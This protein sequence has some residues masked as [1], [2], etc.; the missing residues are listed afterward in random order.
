[1]IPTI[2]ADAVQFEQ[3]NAFTEGKGVYLKWSM[4]SETGNVGFNI[5]RSTFRRSE[6]VT[7]TI[8]PGGSARSSAPTVKGEMY[9]YFD[10]S[11]TL[12]ATYTIKSITFAGERIVSSPVTSRFSAD[13]EKDTGRSLKEL[14]NVEKTRNPSIAGRSLSLTPELQAI[15]RTSQQQADLATHRWVVSQP[16]AK[17][18]VKK[19]GLYR[20]SRSDLQNA[21]FNVSSTSANWRLFMEG[22]EQ[23]I[24]VGPS[25]DYIEFYGKGIDTI[26]S[27]TR[28]YYLLAD[29]VAGKRMTTKILSTLG[30]NAV[31]PNYRVVSEKKEKINYLNSIQNGDAENY[32]GR[33][34]TSSPTTV[35][36]TLTG[37]DTSVAT[38]SITVKMQGFS[39]SVHENNVILNGHNLGTFTGNQRDAYALQDFVIPTSFLVEGTNSL[40]L[41]T[42]VSSD[43]SLFDSVS[44]SFGRK[45]QADQNKVIFYTPGYRRI[46]ASGF[47]TSGIRVFDT[48]FDSYPQE[49]LNLPV[50]QN[51]GTFSV[52]FPPHRA[53]MFYAMESGAYLTP[54]S[55]TLNAPSTLSSAANGADMLIISYS[56]PDYI[57]AAESWASYRRRGTGGGYNVKVIDVADIFDEF[58]YGVP[59]AASLNAFLDFAYHNWQTQPRYTLF[60][61]DASYDPKNYEGYG[62]WN[63][64][65]VKIV[66]LIYGESGSD[67]ALGDFD[68][69]GLNEI[70]IGRVTARNS[71]VINTA[72]SKT[73]KFESP[74]NQTLDRGAVF[75]YDLP[76]GYDFEAMSGILCSELQPGTPCTMVDRGAAD[77]KTTLINNLNR[78]PYLVNYAGH[79]ASGTWASTN[80]FGVSDVS[81]LNNIDGPS[82]YVMLTC[83]NGYFSL[84][85]FDSLSE[86]LLSSPTGGAAATW[87]STTETTPDIQLIMGQRFYHQLKLG[88][89]HR[90]GDLIKDAKT[91]IPFSSDVRLSWTL[92]GDPALKVN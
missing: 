53:A 69:D 34:V 45:Y 76:N 79:G 23:A 81:S 88:Q 65:P 33:I 16:G 59:S 47:S 36:F 15:V 86:V 7:P 17:I 25:D 68:G 9:T 1:M 90:L 91:A 29:T 60:L 41:S 43:Y 63:L 67:E 37:I 35:P 44:V 5:Y 48:T 40:E 38:A 73:Q 70:A 32:W 30:G 80:F 77:S 20:V 64:V 50:I 54:A 21:G 52:K 49:V 13:L 55:V 61:G 84:P 42:T 74:E 2:K 56:A 66:N 92:L 82:I 39:F 85:A 57:A 58:N 83:L 78:N 4:T 62:Y 51:G 28:M 26:E 6:L 8:I 27:D 31:S 14:L 19:E 24:I 18:G 10:P 72:L 71:F 22:V 46:E 75:A 89:I 3:I 12:G 87:A 11:G